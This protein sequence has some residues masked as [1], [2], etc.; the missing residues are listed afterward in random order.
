MDGILV[1]MEDV[2]RV[3]DPL[4]G[5]VTDSA[6]PSLVASMTE[7][8]RS[9]GETSAWTISTCREGSE[10]E[11]SNDEDFGARLGGP[12]LGPAGT[13]EAVLP[14]EEEKEKEPA[15]N[16][17]SMACFTRGALEDPSIVP[18][19]SIGGKWDNK[20]RKDSGP[21]SFTRAMGCEE[22]DRSAWKNGKL[23]G[24][25]TLGGVSHPLSS[26]HLSSRRWGQGKHAGFTF[27][28]AAMYEDEL[29]HFKKGS[30]QLPAIKEEIDS[31]MHRVAAFKLGP[32]GMAGEHR[33][34]QGPG[35]KGEEGGDTC[36]G[37]NGVAMHM[38]GAGRWV[39]EAK[40]SLFREGLS[41]R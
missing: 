30:T 3:E 41:R 35:K 13:G 29:S 21:Q 27:T 36:D 15:L 40:V 22:A 25:G 8:D 38:E 11:D 39:K 19:R 1:G 7:G 26:A 10:D 24:R 16:G 4:D 28:S 9:D 23:K 33:G 5:D 17:F 2:A 14:Q 6:P 37:G 32:Q 18:V 31:G 20:V 12:Q 34:K